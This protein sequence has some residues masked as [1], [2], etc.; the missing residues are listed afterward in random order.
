MTSA[1]D[2]TTEAYERAASLLATSPDFKILRRF[3]PPRR[4]NDAS[5]SFLLNAGLYVDVESTGLDVERD[6]IIELAVVPFAYDDD[7]N[8]YLVPEGWSQFEE[9]AIPISQEITDLTGITN[10]ML[11]GCRIN[12]A[13]VE[14][15][16]KTTDLVIAHNADFD[17]KL[18]ERRFP[19]FARVDWACSYR[20]VPWQAMGVLGGK[21]P[22]ILAEACGGFYDAHRALDDCL[23][24]VHVLATAQHEGKPA[25]AHLLESA[26]RPSCRVWARNSHFSKKDQLKAKGYRWSPDPVKCWFKDV[27][28]AE[29]EAERVWL[30]DVGVY[31]PDVTRLTARDRYSTRAG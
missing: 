4:Y 25:L 10:D 18:L 12:D 3:L 9:P 26:R 2:Y 30:R 6:Q 23:V 27:P 22:H 15:T 14:A 8:V 21:L 17:R 5:S 11:R 24:G 20:E 19:V 13:L 1:I 29:L 16:V 31:R 7:G 28:E